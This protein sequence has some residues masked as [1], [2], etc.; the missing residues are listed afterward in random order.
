M[1]MERR[2]LPVRIDT[3]DWQDQ[4]FA[5]H[6][7]TRS[8]FLSES[9]KRHGVLAPPWLLQTD[10]GRPVIVDGYK[11]LKWLEENRATEVE[12]LL[13]AASCDRRE[14]LIQRLEA[15]MA[16]AL[17]NLAEKAQIVARLAE[18]MP[19]ERVLAEYFPVLNLASR[20][21]AIDRWSRLAAAEK[22]L[23]SALAND[24]LCERVALELIDWPSA[25]I[26]RMIA[27][28]CEL[29]C[30]A[31]IQV[32]I[33]ERIGEIALNHGKSRAEIVDSREVQD[34]LQDADRHHRRKTQDLRDLLQRWRFPRLSAR[35]QRFQRNLDACGLPAPIRIQPPPAFEG[36]SWQLQ[37]QFSSPSELPKLLAAVQ[38]LAVSSKLPELLEQPVD[39][40]VTVANPVSSKP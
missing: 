15:K 25:E 31:S 32:E 14:L 22:F 1:A 11:R 7:H 24:R 36:N 28:F 35:Q 30:S 39:D 38:V 21:Q 40:E 17:V 26:Q 33:A 5:I 10:E 20:P 16:G 34:I 13:F 6:S 29:R 4:S 27:L 23:L 2:L 3:L 9:L 37:I 8:T 18:V 12:C 19:P